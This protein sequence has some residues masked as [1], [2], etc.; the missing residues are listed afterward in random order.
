MRI[1]YLKAATT[2][3]ELKELYREMAKKH[4][5]DKGGDTEAMKKINLE[6]EYLFDRLP[7]TKQEQASPE[8]AAEYMKIISDI[9]AIPGIYIEL[10]GTW[11]W[12]TGNTKP[13]K[14]MLKAAGFKFAGKKAAWY[15]H[16]GKYRKRSKKKLSM[17]EIRDLYGSTTIEKEERAALG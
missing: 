3:K 2:R 15:W 11:V 16:S 4:H 8:T 7:T 12:V 5:P 6:F 17:Q 13:I 9:I 14:D 1:D 10:C